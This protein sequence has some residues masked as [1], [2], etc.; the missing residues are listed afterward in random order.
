M[1][2][3]RFNISLNNLTRNLSKEISVFSASVHKI[4]GS[5]MLNWPVSN[6]S[7]IYLDRDFYNNPYNNDIVNCQ[8][9]H[10]LLHSL[11]E[12]RDPLQ[13]FMGHRIEIDAATNL[14]KQS[15]YTGINEATTQMFAEMIEK[16]N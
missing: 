6:G 7:E 15:L 9:T 2:F 3:R 12:L 8:I 1:F 4:H 5:R 10:E 14:P 16:N 11:S 13:Y